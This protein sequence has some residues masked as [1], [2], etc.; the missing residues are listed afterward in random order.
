MFNKTSFPV[1]NESVCGLYLCFGR[2]FPT[3]VT[4]QVTTLLLCN[5]RCRY[6]AEVTLCGHTYC[7]TYN[8]SVYSASVL[9][10]S[11][12]TTEWGVEEREMR[13]GR[14][15]ESYDLYSHK[16]CN[17]KLLLRTICGH[18]MRFTTTMPR[19]THECK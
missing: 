19:N 15:P 17:C 5:P 2:K 18:G 6:L 7:S 10:S 1:I 4:I 9:F 3:P 8:I 14:Q 11:F 13:S 12:R 16:I